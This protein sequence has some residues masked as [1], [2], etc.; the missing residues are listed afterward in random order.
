MASMAT[1][2]VSSPM[3]SICDVVGIGS[4]EHSQDIAGDAPG[5]A[6]ATQKS[7]PSLS[8]QMRRTV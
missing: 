6:A 2:A 5:S 1:W 7:I 8:G 4:D 3:R